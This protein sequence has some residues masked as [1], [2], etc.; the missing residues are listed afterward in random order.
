MGDAPG[1]HEP[2]VLRAAAE[3][4][5]GALVVG[6]ARPLVRADAIGDI[7]E[8]GFGVVQVAARKAASHNSIPRVGMG[9]ERRD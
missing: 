5:V 6:E 4:V 1:M 9:G 2:H 7:E 3:R 8:A